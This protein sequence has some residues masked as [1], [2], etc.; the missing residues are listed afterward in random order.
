M[1]ACFKVRWILIG[2]QKCYHSSTKNNHSETILFLFVVIII[3]VLLTS[4]S[5]R[6]RTTI[7]TLVIVI[8]IVTILCVNG[9][10]TGY[11]SRGSLNSLKR[12]EN[13]YEHE[14]LSAVFL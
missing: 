10:N 12:L 5:H 9:H 8:I 14:K 4:I 13:H 6:I 3:V 1:P 2:C 11:E 7:K